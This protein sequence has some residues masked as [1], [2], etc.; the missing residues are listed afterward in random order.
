ML[1]RFVELFGT[2]YLRKKIYGGKLILL[3]K[4]PCRNKAEKQKVDK[5][6]KQ[7][8]GYIGRT[9]DFKRKISEMSKLGQYELELYTLGG[10]PYNGSMSDLKSVLDYVIKF[11]STVYGHDGLRSL[12]F[13]A[14]WNLPDVPRNFKQ[15]V[16]SRQKETEKIMD[17]FSDLREVETE[18]EDISQQK[19]Q[20]L[21]WLSGEIEASVSQLNFINS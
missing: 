6:I 18:I 3:L 15:F 13:N 21:G 17:I 10:K 7:V 9:E 8:A 11:S 5:K 4:I 1:F 19:N 12:E 2:H 14:L 20:E 16:F